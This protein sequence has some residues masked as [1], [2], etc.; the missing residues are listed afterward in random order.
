M[1]APAPRQLSPLSSPGKADAPELY[2]DSRGFKLQLQNGLSDIFSA[3]PSMAGIGSLEARVWNASATAP[4]KR[5][6]GGLLPPRKRRRP[7]TT[8]GPAGERQD[9]GPAPLPM[10]APPSAMDPG[11]GRTGVLPF[12]LPAPRLP[13]SISSLPLSRPT[14]RLDRAPAAAAHSEAAVMKRALR[15]HQL[16]GDLA[17]SAAVLAGGN[18]MSSAVPVA[19]DGAVAANDHDDPADAQAEPQEAAAPVTAGPVAAGPVAAASAGA[20]PPAPLRLRNDL[21]QPPPALQAYM[22]RSSAA[23][24]LA[25]SVAPAPAPPGVDVVALTAELRRAVRRQVCCRCCLLFRL[26]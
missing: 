2:G 6:P 3:A 5:P 10:P 9:L 21:S 1:A 14:S 19:P 17:V 25:S 11:G 23:A 24:R 20:A 15:F 16:S 18:S 4:A 8:R 22:D 26:S 7:R 12:L 13:P